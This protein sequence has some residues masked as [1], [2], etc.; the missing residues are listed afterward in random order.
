MKNNFNYAVFMQTPDTCLYVFGEKSIANVASSNPGTGYFLSSS[1][2]SHQ[3]IPKLA[4]VFFNSGVQTS[5]DLGYSNT[6]SKWEHGH[7]RVHL[8]LPPK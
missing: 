6:I 7:P 5:V 8:K 2:G 3:Y 4:S 1:D